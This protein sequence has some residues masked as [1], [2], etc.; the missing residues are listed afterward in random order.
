VA[1]PL[2]DN[3]KGVGNIGLSN[4]PIPADLILE[5]EIKRRMD[6]AKWG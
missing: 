5:I 6:F 4:R 3:V 2:S 1:P